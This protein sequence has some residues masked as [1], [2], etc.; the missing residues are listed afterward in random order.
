LLDIGL[1]VRQRM[2]ESRLCVRREREGT[3]ARVRLD[4]T[5]RKYPCKIT[6][7]FLAV[8][9]VSYS[10]LRPHSCGKHTL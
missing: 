5:P 9:S 6:G 1:Q 10:S 8:S 4:A 2:R 7:A 3:T